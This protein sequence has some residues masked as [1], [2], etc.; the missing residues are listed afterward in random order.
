MPRIN[1]FELAINVRKH[2]RFSK[3]PMLAISSRADKTYLDE[4]IKSGYNIYLEKLKPADLIAAL[5]E[6]SRELKEVA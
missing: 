4:G 2:A 1:G 5:G 6:L 3:I